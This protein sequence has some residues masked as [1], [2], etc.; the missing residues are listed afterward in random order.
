MLRESHAL[1]EAA[2]HDPPRV[3]IV[4]GGFGGAS[5]ARALERRLPKAEIVLLS[6]ENY[7]TYNPL[8][9]EVVGASILPSHVVAPLR[10]MVRRTHVRTVHVTDVD[11]AAREVRYLGDGPG[12]FGYDQLVLAYGASANL[13]LVP[14]MG[15]YALPLKTL[16]DAL[17]LRNRIIARL[18]QAE[19]THDP[20]MRAWLTTFVVVGGGFSGVEVA[21]EINDFIH[22]CRRYYHC[23][24]R[25]ARVIMIHSGAHLL[26]ELPEKLGRITATIMRRRNVEL[27]LSARTA[28]VDDRGVVLADGERIATGTVI[29]TI[30]SRPNSLSYALPVAKERGRIK[31]DADMA[32]PGWPGVWALGDCAAV[33]NAHD[34]S[35][36]PPTAQL[37]LSQ[38]RQ[39]AHNIARAAQG[40]ATR[41]FRYR[42]KGVMSAV[43]HNRAVA[44]VFGVNL[45][46]FVAWLLWRGYYLMHVPTL[47]RKARLYLEWSWAMFFPPDTVHLRFTRT[48]RTRTQRTSAVRDPAP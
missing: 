47:A 22:A 10:Q 41:P 32:L 26:P 20:D 3:V 42:P 36:C 14:G 15:K 8:L 7:I 37:A 28:A 30:G 27:Y 1:S 44:K 12:A 46:G 19:L 11:L 9:P 43:G 18:E 34:A 24:A 33:T 21:G 38:A 39:L 2:P 6:K 45:S 40:E 25:H 5:V 35:I 31:T 17:F 13:E 29:C 16:G 4:G 23:L 48:E